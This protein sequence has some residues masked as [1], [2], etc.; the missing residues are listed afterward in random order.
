MK[1]AS[2]YKRKDRIMLFAVSTTTNGVGITV[3]PVLSVAAD[4]VRGLGEATPAVLEG[5]R[6]NVPQPAQR[7][8]GPSFEPVLKAAAV[9]MHGR[10]DTLGP[11]PRTA[12]LQVGKRRDHV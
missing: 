7:E 2:V 3:D 12:L 4:D 11:W 6:E 9:S 1:W 8:W 5:S 10:A